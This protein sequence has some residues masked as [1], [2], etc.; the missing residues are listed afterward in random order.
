MSSSKL[1]QVR[2]PYIKAPTTSTH[3]GSDSSAERKQIAKLSEMGL[4]EQADGTIKEADD[5]RKWFRIRIATTGDANGK[6]Y[7]FR[8][9]LCGSVYYSPAFWVKRTRNEC[10]TIKPRSTPPQA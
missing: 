9:T 3:T 8:L 5:N 1:P 4:L 10:F 6:Y 7:H 2:K